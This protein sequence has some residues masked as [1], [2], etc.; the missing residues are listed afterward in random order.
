M[1]CPYNG[2]CQPNKVFY[3]SQHK[4]NFHR[5]YDTKKFVIVKIEFR[6]HQMDVRIS[7]ENETSKNSLCSSFKIIA[8]PNYFFI[9]MV[10]IYI[11][12]IRKRR[13][14]FTQ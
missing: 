1:K 8:K 14:G 10:Y 2:K 5:G 11:G 3:F 9:Y 12:M 4:N 7:E 13:R 6:S